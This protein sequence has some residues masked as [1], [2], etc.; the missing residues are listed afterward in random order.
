YARE[1]AWHPRE[2]AETAGR[3]AHRPSGGAG[4]GGAVGPDGHRYLRRVR[5]TAARE[6]ERRHRPWHVLGAP[7]AGWRGEG[8][9]VR[10]PAGAGPP[11]R[12]RQ[13]APCRGLSRLLRDL[14][15]PL[16]GHR[17]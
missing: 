11:R 2:P 7:R 1:P 17:L 12:Q 13:P 14:S 4:G 9:L 10:S 8:R 15:R 16:V 5:A 3:W 6:P